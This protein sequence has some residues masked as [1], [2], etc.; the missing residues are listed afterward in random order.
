MAD[1]RRCPSPSCG[2]ADVIVGRAVWTGWLEC[3]CR[4]CWTTWRESCERGIA[5][6][7][8]AKGEKTAVGIVRLVEGSVEGILIRELASFLSLGRRTIR[9]HA[10]RLAQEGRVEIVRDGLGPMLLKRSA[11]EVST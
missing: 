4:R 11:K 5:A 7:S 3:C 9:R 8:R 1:A 2:S 10:K 6:L